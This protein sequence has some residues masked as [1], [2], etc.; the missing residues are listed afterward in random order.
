MITANYIP[1]SLTSVPSSSMPWHYRS[2]HNSS[3]ANFMI[4]RHTHQCFQ[5]IYFHTL[6]ITLVNQCLF[7]FI[8]SYIFRLTEAKHVQPH[9]LYPKSTRDIVTME[10]LSPQF[11]FVGL[12]LA[13]IRWANGNHRIWCFSFVCQLISFMGEKCS[14]VTSVTTFTRKA[15]HARVLGSMLSSN[16][17]K[18]SFLVFFVIYFPQLFV[19][20]TDNSS[21]Y[22]DV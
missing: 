18:A 15:F 12:S 14:V 7:Y 21:H 5:A 6:A 8:T 13:L 11:L 22:L 4:E 17:H 10:S 16:T 19:L 2:L 9:S 3:F 20:G 1:I